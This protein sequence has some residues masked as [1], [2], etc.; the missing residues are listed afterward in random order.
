M[1]FGKL[2]VAGRGE[3]RVS[4]SGRRRVMWDC[5]CDCGNVVTVNPDNLHSGRQRSCGC[6]QREEAG[7]RLRTHGESKTKLYGIWSS[8]KARC[9][10]KNTVAYKDYGGRGIEMCDEWKHDYDAFRK[11][12]LE[13]GY[14]DDASIDRVDNDLGYSPENCEW[15]TGV[16]QANNRRSNR[17]YTVDGETHNLTEWAHIKGIN[18]KT[19]FNRVYTGV[20]FDEAIKQ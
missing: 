6:L 7:A 3:D 19:L 13:N 2:T 20:P 14:R 16:A 11:W 12:A 9:Y 8:M 17:V 1:R 10:N 18:P 15:V 4:S 5:V